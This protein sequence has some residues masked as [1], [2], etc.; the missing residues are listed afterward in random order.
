MKKV[1]T[2]LYTL[3]QP[4]AAFLIKLIYQ[5]KI[6]NKEVIPQDGSVILAGNHKMA[7]DP[8][9]VTCGTKRIIHF[10]AKDVF[11]HRNKRISF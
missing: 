10:M 2:W 5:P 11:F 6:I 8:V 3:V 9:L 7:F 1:P 4:V